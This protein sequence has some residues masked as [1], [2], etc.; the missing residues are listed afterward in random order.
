MVVLILLGVG[1][2]VLGISVAGIARGVVILRGPPPTRRWSGVVLIFA[3]ALLPV[4]CCSGPSVLFRLHHETP[5]L[6]RYPNSVVKEGMSPDEVR[7]LLGAPHQ[8]NDRDPERV[9]WLYWLDP[10]ELGWFMVTFG[11]DGKVD[12]TGG[13]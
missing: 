1:I 7:T 2:A 11:A 9:T 10:V 3:G 12:H 13:N 4:C 5:P 6:G 8:V